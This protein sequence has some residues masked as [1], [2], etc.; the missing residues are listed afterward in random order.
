M[1]EGIAWITFE[2]ER[3]YRINMNRINTLCCHRWGDVNNEH[4]FTYTIERLLFNSRSLAVKDFKFKGTASVCVTFHHS[5]V[6]KFNQNTH[7]KCGLA[8][9]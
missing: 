4:I 5:T 6:R 7:L 1:S 8:L 3:K 2:E 9:Y